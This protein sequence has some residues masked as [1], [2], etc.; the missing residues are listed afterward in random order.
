MKSTRLCFGDRR[1]SYYTQYTGG[2]GTTLRPV[3]KH[4]LHL[5][6]LSESKNLWSKILFIYRSC[7][8]EQAKTKTFGQRSFSYTSPVIRNKLPYDIRTSQTKS[9]FKVQD[10][11]NKIIIQSSGLHQQ[12][13]HSKFSTSPTKSSFKVQD[14]TNKTHHS[15]SV[16]HQQNS[17]FKFR[18]SQ[19][20][21]IIQIQDFTNK[22]IVQSSGL[23]KQN[24]HSKFRTSQTK[25]IIQ[26]SGL[27]KLNHHSKVLNT[28]L[29][30]T[31]Y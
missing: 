15:N 18:T 26:R 30:S 2:I 23:H 1:H 7:D 13:S 5:L 20:K 17:S 16:L 9:S 8:Q 29:F 28:Y 19:T 10:F 25:L 31:H 24:H 11:T 6:S 4:S 22:I 21:L 14:F 27:H 3:T 12:N